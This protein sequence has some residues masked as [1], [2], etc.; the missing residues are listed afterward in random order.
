[1][2]A[3]WNIE[4]TAWITFSLR[5]L[6]IL[7]SLQAFDKCVC[8]IAFPSEVWNAI[9]FSFDNADFPLVLFKYFILLYFRS[10]HSKVVEIILYRSGTITAEDLNKLKTY[11]YRIIYVLWLF[12]S[13]Y[14]NHSAVGCL[15]YTIYLYT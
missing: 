9:G 14:N 6:F 3:S 15:P 8:G 5:Y 1:M 4:N 11:I 12:V 7:H 13:Q 2:Y 10:L